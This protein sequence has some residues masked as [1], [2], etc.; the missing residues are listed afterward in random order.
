MAAR[1]QGV[2]ASLSDIREKDAG[3]SDSLQWLN[4][5]GPGVKVN[6]IDPRLQLGHVEDFKREFSAGFGGESYWYSISAAGNLDWSLKREDCGGFG[7]SSKYQDASAETNV[8]SLDPETHNYFIGYN[9]QCVRYFNLTDEPWNNP[10]TNNFTG[11]AR[12]GK[13]YTNGVMDSGPV[14]APWASEAAGADRSARDDFPVRGLIISNTSEVV[15]LDLDSYPLIK[16]WMRFRLGSSDNWTMLGSQTRYPI[17]I[18]FFNGNLATCSAGSDGYMAV[19]DFKATSAPIAYLI[20]QSNPC[21][22]WTT[23]RTIVDRNT[24]YFTTT[25]GSATLTTGGAT[26]WRQI[27]LQNDGT[28]LWIACATSRGCFVIRTWDRMTVTT[29]DLSSGTLGGICFDRQQSGHAKRWCSGILFMAMGTY[30]IRNELEYK[31]GLAIHT[32]TDWYRQRGGRG[33]RSCNYVNLGVSI[34][35]LV[36]GPPYIYAAT[37]KGVFR[38]HQGTLVAERR[39]TVGDDYLGT[40]KTLTGESPSISSLRVHS[41]EFGNYLGVGTPFT[42]SPKGLGFAGGSGGGGGFTLVRDF[43]HVVLKS[44]RHPTLPVDGT[45]AIELVTF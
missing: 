20:G 21:F 43:D 7:E 37:A 3:A 8:S 22:V 1:R 28:Y 31:N 36:P 30:I 34:N 6:H 24:W 16:M 45:Q 18:Q 19:V 12:D 2:G 35:H 5:G 11:Y 10:T 39:Y 17:D 33:N 38:I 4:V 13:K 40:Y 25:G 15:I 29:G 14:W 27:A 32:K 23:G 44:L 42:G 26:T 41:N 9:P